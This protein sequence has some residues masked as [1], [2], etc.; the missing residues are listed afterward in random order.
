MFCFRPLTILVALWLAPTA[1]A[2]EA[3]F[4]EA[5]EA[6]QNS[7]LTGYGGFNL[8]GGVVSPTPPRNNNDR[9]YMRT[10]VAS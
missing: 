8:A 4:E 2:E 3:Y 6:S 10:I 9:R 7:N 5:F 1:R